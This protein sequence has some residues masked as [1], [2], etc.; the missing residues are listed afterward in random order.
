MR[1]VGHII[2]TFV[3]GAFLTNFLNAAAS[4][5]VDTRPAGQAA[6]AVLWNP[7][8]NIARRDLYR[9][10][11]GHHD[12][13]CEPYV[14]VKEDLKGS[15]P[16]LDIRDGKGIEWKVKLGMEARPETAASRLMWAVGYF[17]N[18]CYYLP[19]LHIENLPCH[20]LRGQ[21]FVA[22]D[23]SV[24]GARLKKKS[25]DMK[26]IGIWRWKENP[27]VGSREFNGLKVMMALINNWDLKDS[28]NAIFEEEDPSGT[29][30]LS[31][32]MVSDLGA[33]F[34]SGRWSLPLTT[35]KG[36]LKFYNR[37]TFISDTGSDCLDFELGGRPALLRMLFV[38]LLFMK[39]SKMDWIGRDIPRSDVRWIGG[40]LAQLSPSQIRD[41]FR[42]A[43][44]S[45][46]EC[47]GFAQVILRR[48]AELN[49]L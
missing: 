4:T 8:E 13:P 25:A 22:C 26:K 43:G 20:L 12:A 40:L 48:I 23:G 37:S 18:E 27:F 39:Y 34:G 9:G 14:F 5:V 47:E 33:S 19:S 45:T 28:N 30:T 21:E 38:P 15:N 44:Y 6:A 41:A 46:G 49:Y 42:T 29:N 7:V 17:A 31:V 36:N 11:G 35:A 3:L 32:Y 16:K 2:G 24:I 1:R 10:P